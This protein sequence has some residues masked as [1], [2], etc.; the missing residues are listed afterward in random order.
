MRRSKYVMFAVSRTL[1]HHEEYVK[2]CVHSDYGCTNVFW[3]LWV[4]WYVSS[5]QR[6]FRVVN[7]LIAPV[8]S[9]LTTLS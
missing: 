6:T 2:T 3:L 7:E 1:L 8:Q 9:P 4:T 5:R